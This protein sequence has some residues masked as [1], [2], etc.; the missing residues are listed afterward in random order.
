MDDV[1]PGRRRRQQRAEE[2]C[3]CHYV[4]CTPDGSAGF[5][6]RAA[7]RRPPGPVHLAPAEQTDALSGGTLEHKAAVSRPINI[8]APAPTTRRRPPPGSTADR[9]AR[10]D[11]SSPRS[12]TS[13]PSFLRF[14]ASAA[15]TTVTTTAA[16]A[17]AAAT[18]SA[19]D[20]RQRNQHTG[21]EQDGRVRARASERR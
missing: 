11:S 8:D 1:R 15:T 12:H 18:N 20:D 2:R 4:V 5:S 7:R 19:T 21:Y 10:C 6:L 3:R 9:E 17:V 16:V 14:F 13:D